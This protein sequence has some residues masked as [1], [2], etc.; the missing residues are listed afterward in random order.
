[1]AFAPP[2]LSVP[3]AS[4]GGAL[5]GP[6]DGLFAARLKAGAA[7]AAATLGAVA[8]AA[9]AFLLAAAAAGEPT[10]YV[11]ARIGG[12]PT[13]LSGPLHGLGGSLRPDPFQTLTLAM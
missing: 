6:P 11:P 13:W 1:M 10:Q 12:W 8:I 7:G 5:A 2:R 4:P 9:T 3:R